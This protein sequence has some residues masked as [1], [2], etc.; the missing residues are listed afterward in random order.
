MRQWLCACLE[1]YTFLSVPVACEEDVIDYRFLQLLSLERRYIVI[2]T[3]KSDED[4]PV[5]DVL[6]EV[7]AQPFEQWRSPSAGEGP[8]EA[9]E[10][11]VY[12]DPISIDILS[13]CG[14]G[15]DNRPEWRALRC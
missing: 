1:Q 5:E 11:F 12:S 2:E 3:F 9:A 8:G 6:Y 7:F 4:D 13:M 15:Q 10:V 14:G